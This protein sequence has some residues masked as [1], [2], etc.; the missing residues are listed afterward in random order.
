M[1][2]KKELDAAD[3]SFLL[4][5]RTGFSWNHY[6][7]INLLRKIEEECKRT[8]N[9]TSLDREIA[10]GIWYSIN[11]IKDWV[12]HENFPKVYPS[13]YYEIAFGLLNEL[14]YYYFMGESPYE[15]ENEIDGKVRSL[16]SYLSQ[17]Q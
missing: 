8:Q 6:A 16:H 1:T 7:F 17:R 4:E 13:K 14:G 10:S 15:S 12:N 9:D 2:L 3:G 5:L 11:F